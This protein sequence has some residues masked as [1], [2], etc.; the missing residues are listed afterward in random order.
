M[1]SP[2]G[3]VLE[4]APDWF[5]VAT[6][7]YGGETSDLGFFSEVSIFIRTFGIGNKSRGARG[8]HKP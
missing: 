2:F 1:V 6:E 7:A 8:A 4:R 5:F 3:R